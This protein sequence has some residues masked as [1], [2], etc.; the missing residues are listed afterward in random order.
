MRFKIVSTSLL[1]LLALTGFSQIRESNEKEIKKNLAFLADD[2]LKGRAAGSR[3]D[4]IAARYIA[5]K[6]SKYGFKPLLGNNS[7]VPFEFIRF[8]ERG[9]GSILSIDDTDLLENIDYSVPPFS[10][11]DQIRGKLAFI[12]EKEGAD[13]D[14]K[15]KIVVIESDLDSIPFKITALRD[16]GVVGV[17][18]FS[19]D[20]INLEKRSQ[21]SGTSI[22]VAQI[23]KETA[24]KI[25]S[26]QGK[27]VFYKAVVNVVKGKSYNVVM[28]LGI[29]NAK[30][31]ILLGAH[32]D[33]LGLGGKGSGSMNPKI[34]EIHNGADDNAS[35][36]SSVMEAGRLLA[37]RRGELKHNIVI[38]AFGGEERGMLGSRIIADTLKKLNQS[39]ALMFNL[40]MV[41]RLV[42]N[43]LQVGGVGT[44]LQADSIIR[45]VN[46]DHNFSLTITKDGYG[47]SDHSSFYTDGVPVLYFTTGVHKQYHT[48]FDDIELINF[49]GLVYVTNFITSIAYNIASSGEVPDYRKI[50]APATPSMASFKVTLGLIPDFTY[51]VGDGF[52]AGP[53]TEGKPAQIGGML[54]GDII[55]AINSKKVSNI[56]D[57]M[58]RLG[59]LKKGDK[60]VVD[61]RRD[62]K[63]IKLTIQL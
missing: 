62:G 22:P 23:S 11:S 13:S 41:G 47:P 38:V 14:L 33:H 2:K 28:Q 42:E 9:K 21:S 30:R 44:F 48:P 15:G 40:D 60:I 51:E 31:T 8:R 49:S 36:V 10:A 50:N 6:L 24:Q 43:K 27:D 25:Y 53:V 32:Y 45:K 12:N 55:T 57:Y 29:D 63:E 3:E 52:R 39:P 56:Y 20:S 7:V 35:G 59:E 16:R 1:L 26:S 61:V 37:K 17:F 54:T 58:A 4:K 34:K 18:F 46:K 19:K 5:S